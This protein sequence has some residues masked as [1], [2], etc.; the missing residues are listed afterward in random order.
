MQDDDEH[1]EQPGNGVRDA[2][3]E[4]ARGRQQEPAHRLAPR[5]RVGKPP[6][7]E[8]DRRVDQHEVQD[9]RQRRHQRRARRR[10]AARRGPRRRRRARFGRPFARRW[11]RCRWP[12]ARRARVDA[13]QHQQAE[14][15][16]P[17]AAA[18]PRAASAP[19][20]RASAASSS[21]CCSRSAARAAAPSTVSP[22]S[23][24]TSGGVSAST[25]REP[26]VISQPPSNGSR[27][28]GTGDAA[29]RPDRRAR[30]PAPSA[31]SAGPRPSTRAL[32]TTIGRLKNVSVAASPE[33]S[34]RIAAADRSAPR[35]PLPRQ[36]ASATHERAPAPCSRVQ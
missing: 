11:R 17:T 8:A 18:A 32:S 24:S 14:R 28:D 34:A 23:S 27:C 19:G 22:D 12:T 9:D 3:P 2:E 7:H 36:T 16:A 21:A 1:R 30:A 4:V 20:V 29:A 6:Q 33:G 35:G 31:R 15:S 25:P 5:P 13:P 10:A 26:T